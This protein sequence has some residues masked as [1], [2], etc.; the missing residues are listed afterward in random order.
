[1]SRGGTWRIIPV[2]KW[3]RTIVSLLRRVVP[4]PNGLNDL[5]TGV[6]NQLLTGLN[7]Q[8]G[9]ERVQREESTSDKSVGPPGELVGPFIESEF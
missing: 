1:M 2:S 9:G 8:V 5:Q 3:L 7:L 4:L 6:T